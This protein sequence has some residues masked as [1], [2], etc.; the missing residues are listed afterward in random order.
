MFATR[1][2]FVSCLLAGALVLVPVA[3]AGDATPLPT[4]MTIA[5]LVTDLDQ[6]GALE[7]L[8]AA[9]DQESV[10]LFNADGRLVY[11]TVGLPA[12]LPAGAQPRFD[13]RDGDGLPDLVAGERLLASGRD[14]LAAASRRGCPSFTEIWNSG[15]ALN[16]VWD[17]ESA[18]LD[19]DGADE[20]VGQAYYYPGTL[21]RV[22]ENDAD[23]SFTETWASTQQSTP[24][25]V[26]LA[27]G[28]TDHDDQLEILAGEA[29]TL[30][31]LYLWENVGDDTFAPRSLG[32][33][34]DWQVRGITVDDSDRDGRVEIIGAG[35]SSTDGG[36]VKIFEHNGVPGENAYTE[37]HEYT[38]PSYLLGIEA[39]DADNDGRR[40]VLLKVGGWAGFPTYIRRL[41]YNPVTV[42]WEHKL[43][44]AATT[45]LPISAL[46]ADLD[47]D[48]ENELVVGSSSVI[49]IYES[50]ADDGFTPVWTSDFYI[51]GN[52]M[53]LTLG[54][55]SGYGYPTVASCSFEG[56]ID[57][58]GYDGADYTRL[59]DPAL[60]VSGSARSIDLDLL[61]GADSRIDLLLAESSQVRI[62]VYECDAASAVGD[63]DPDAAIESIV[64]GGLDIRLARSPFRAGDAIRCRLPSGSGSARL[65]ILDLRGELVRSVDLGG[66]DAT[67]IWHWDGRDGQ[68]RRQAS[69]VYL[70]RLSAVGRI[71]NRSLVLVR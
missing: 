58:F 27:V 16:N 51:P 60:T 68:G 29:G 38:T 17:S 11:T 34:L 46:I 18:D 2:R 65:Q 57:L 5:E 9:W 32:F 24:S 45:G 41:E 40:E 8:H 35:S 70:V 54:P 67:R 63:T 71:A 53:D 47:N 66:G 49:Y 64:P 48:D 22:F 23:N 20:L 55:D 61:D 26:A 36:S 33:Q 13:D 30:G 4:G 3:I 42:T 59:L 10:Q 7:R 12:A 6:D 43:F 52:V 1:L 28:E 15:P 31:R 62:A 44:E 50:L 25:I 39:G 69:G 37:V 21:V 56:Q 19:G 14:L